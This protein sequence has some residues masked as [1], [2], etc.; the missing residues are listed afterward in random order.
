MIP[1]L[2]LNIKTYLIFIHQNNYF[3]IFF[4]NILKQFKINNNNNLKLFFF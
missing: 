1:A 3:L 4:I 2:G